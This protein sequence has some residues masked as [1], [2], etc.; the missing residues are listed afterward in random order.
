MLI[1]TLNLDI[2]L[3]AG[4]IPLFRSSIIELVGRENEIFHNHD[5]SSESEGHYHFGYPLVQYAVRK[6]RATIIGLGKGA[7]AIYQELLPKLGNG[8]ELDGQR[9]LVRHYHIQ[10]QEHE[11]EIRESPE[12]YGL[13]GWIGL[14]QRNYRRWKDQSNGLS[15]MEI[16]SGALTGQLRSLGKTIGIDEPKQITAEVM[17]VHNQKR[18]RWHKTQLIRFHIRFRTNIFLPADIGIGRCVAFGYGQVLPVEVY[19]R[20][21]IQRPVFVADMTG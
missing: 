15:R 4:D 5:N 1:T 9:V 3:H 21:M 17:E 10:Q 6:R 19:Q 18:V 12:E 11:W 2:P 8:M 7:E 16:L 20:I 13:Y 14:N